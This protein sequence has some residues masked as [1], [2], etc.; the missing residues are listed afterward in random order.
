MNYLAILA[1]G[2]LA[3]IIGSIWH[4]PLFGK[5]T[6]RLM[7]SE[8]MTPEQKEKMRKQMWGMYFLQFVLSIVTIAILDLFI[9]H[10][11]G[12]ASGLGVAL[13]V[14]FGFVMTS[15]ASGALWSGKSAS[16]SWKMFFIGTGGQLVTFIVYA[17]VLTAWK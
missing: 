7:G 16:D 14:W 2:V 3:M 9:M 15:Y 11:S 12:M 17:L 6:M 13:L 1:C 10:W 4:G 8:T 5:E